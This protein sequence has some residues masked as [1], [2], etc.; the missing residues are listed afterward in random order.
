MR[1]TLASFFVLVS[2]AGLLAGLGGTA[3]AADVALP[4]CAAVAEPPHLRVGGTRMYSTGTFSCLNAAPGMSVTVCIEER[5]SVDG[6]WW[7]SGCTTVKDTES[8]SSIEATHSIGVPVSATFLRATVTGVNAN[9]DRA[10]FT[11]PPVWWF[12]CACYIG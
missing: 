5:Y 8:R 2:T 4:R 3:S 1:R 9:G 11:T 7:S 10:S 6:P 12:N